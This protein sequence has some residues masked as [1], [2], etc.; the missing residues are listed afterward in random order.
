M[1]ALLD[2]TAPWDVP[3]SLAQH[4][5]IFY[6]LVVAGLV[7][8]A[9]FVRTWV[10]TGEVSPRYRTALYASMCICGVAFL[11]YL[12]L[13][14]KFD[15]GYDLQNGSYVP[16]AESFG[17]YL[18]RYMDW[19]VTVPLLMVEALAVSAV[20]GARA[21]KTR[22]I[23]MASAFLMIFT[24]YLGAGV[25]GHGNSTSSLL[26]WGIIST[27][28]F[29]VIYVVLFGVLRRSRASLSA[30]VYS[31]YSKALILLLSVWGWYPIAYAIANWA[32]GGNVTTVV[33]VG[34]SLADI[35]AKAGFGAMIHK[36][37]KLRTAEDVNAGEDTHPE[38]VWISSVKYSDGVQS[39]L[40]G[41]SASRLESLLQRS[42]AD[43]GVAQPVGNGHATPVAAVGPSASRHDGVGTV[44]RA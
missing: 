21:T 16:N 19:S 44:P 20:T 40:Q 1:Y 30:E 38:S 15:T 7:L 28:F 14:V 42:G 25:I 9:Q 34:F 3:L 36:I 37:A 5:L 29:A 39:P 43:G 17:S 10:S 35:A 23:L 4:E 22:F 18:P 24:G 41:L 6:S 27:I 12:Y 13:A 11:S 26:V 31:T 2:V 8:F 33:Q 32:S